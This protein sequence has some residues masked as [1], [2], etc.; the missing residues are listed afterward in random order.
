MYYRR[1]NGVHHQSF[2]HTPAAAVPSRFALTW[3]HAWI[4]CPVG[5]PPCRPCH[6]HAAL[7]AAPEVPHSCALRRQ[8]VELDVHGRAAGT[9]PPLG[10]VGRSSAWSGPCPVLSR[11]RPRPPAPRVGRGRHKTDS[12]SLLLLFNPPVCPTRLGVPQS[13]PRL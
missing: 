8:V 9:D 4:P 12:F 7:S 6:T 11:P 3:G 13:R 2:L 1:V 10:K 5:P